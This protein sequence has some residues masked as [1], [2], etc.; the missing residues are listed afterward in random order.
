MYI[1][2]RIYRL[3]YLALVCHTSYSEFGVLQLD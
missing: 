2:L 1:I 3:M